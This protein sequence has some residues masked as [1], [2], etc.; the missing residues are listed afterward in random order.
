MF[1]KNAITKMSIRHNTFYTNWSHHRTFS[2]TKRYSYRLGIEGNLRFIWAL[3]V[4]G[5]FISIEI[6]FTDTTSEKVDS[7]VKKRFVET[8]ENIALTWMLAGT[9]LWATRGTILVRN[10]L[11]LFPY[12]GLTGYTMSKLTPDIHEFKGKAFALMYSSALFTGLS[13]G[14]AFH[15]TSVAACYPGFWFTIFI[16]FS[17]MYYH[18]LHAER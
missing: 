8:F 11:L 14:V 17:F 3:G 7:K 10:K 9:T 5:M 13:L 1:F 15:G 6:Y 4:A 2:T 18:L 16:M 12:L